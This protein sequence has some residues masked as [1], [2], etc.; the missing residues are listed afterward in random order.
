[1]LGTP[2]LTQEK[3]LQ[4]P[5]SNLQSQEADSVANATA[6]LST[7][8]DR[9]LFEDGRKILGKSAGGMLNTAIR[10]KGK[11][12][13]VGILE[14]CRDKDPQ[15]A[16]ADLAAALNGSGGPMTEAEQRRCVP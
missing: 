6:Q 9:A 12:W 14:T 15:A 4:S 8:I 1:M 16:R 11:P 5:I 13:L 2:S 10:K 7:S 3:A